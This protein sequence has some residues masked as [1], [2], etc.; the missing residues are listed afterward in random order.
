MAAVAAVVGETEENRSFH[1]ARTGGEEGLSELGEGRTKAVAPRWRCEVEEGGERNTGSR[2][3][4]GVG[5][6]DGGL[7]ARVAV[8]VPGDAV[9]A[10]EEEE[11]AEAIAGVRR[12]RLLGNTTVVVF[13]FLVVVVGLLLGDS[14]AFTSTSG[15]VATRNWPAG[16]GSTAVTR[17]GTTALFRLSSSSLS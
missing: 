3:E 5:T 7:S 13:A 16:E 4:E 14:F 11:E 1:F 17:V 15:F 2:V 12:P 6:K 8:V 9:A 10:A